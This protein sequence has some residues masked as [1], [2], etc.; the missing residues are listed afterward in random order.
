MYRRAFSWI[1]KSL[2]KTTWRWRPH[3]GRLRCLGP[4][5]RRLDPQTTPCIALVGSPSPTRRKLFYKVKFKYILGKYTAPP[6]TKVHKHT[7]SWT[8]TSKSN[9]I[10]IKL[11]LRLW[12]SRSLLVQWLPFSQTN[13]PMLRRL[14]RI[15]SHQSHSMRPLSNIFVPQKCHQHELSLA[16]T[17][18]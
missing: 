2:G 15:L 16:T 3:A 14:S 12:F 17:N 13:S 4:L 8:N 9:I 18:H 5:P 7:T 1:R 10:Q 6:S 11:F